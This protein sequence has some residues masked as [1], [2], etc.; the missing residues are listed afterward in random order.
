MSLPVY[1]PDHVAKGLALLL[2]QWRT[3]S[4]L[5]GILATYLR[6]FQTLENVT[7]DV[8]NSRMLDTAVGAQLDMLGDLVGET[9]RGRNDIDY[10][11]AVR[12]RI[13]VNRSQ[14][15]AVDVI[16]VATQGNGNTPAI[17]REYP[18]NFAWEVEI[19]NSPSPVTVAKMLQQTK[20]A[21]SRGY[22]IYTTWP[23]VDTLR[24]DSVSAPAAANVWAH[25]SG[26]PVKRWA[27]AIAV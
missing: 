2:Q 16:D 7:W 14:G 18:A 8:I 12:L 9:R 19:Y 6:Q 13:R 25:V 22:V 27:G 26:P 10:R 20:A 17:Y 11:A 21:G 15:R 5:K 24:W 4:K 3:S 23:A 1:E